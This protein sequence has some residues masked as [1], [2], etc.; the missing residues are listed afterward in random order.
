MARLTT[1][2]LVAFALMLGASGVQG[3][4]RW[5]PPAENLSRQSCSSH[6]QALFGNGGAEDCILGSSVG[7]TYLLVPVEDQVVPD[8]HNLQID[9][10]HLSEVTKAEDTSSAGFCRPLSFVARQ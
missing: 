4:R 6:E 10:K 8:R 7:N 1:T 3:D 5:A 2:Q 9:E